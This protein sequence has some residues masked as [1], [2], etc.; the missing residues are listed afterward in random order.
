MLLIPQLLFQDCQTVQLRRQKLP[1]DL[2]V[3]QLEATNHHGAKRR[4]LKEKPSLLVESKVLLHLLRRLTPRLPKQNH[5]KE[6]A[7]SHQHCVAA[8]ALINGG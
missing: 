6:Q 3:S 5:Q 4:L 8:I 2:L 1:L 7:I